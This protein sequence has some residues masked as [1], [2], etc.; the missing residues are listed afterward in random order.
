MGALI[1]GRGNALLSEAEWRKI[2]PIILGEKPDKGF[3][4]SAAARILKTTPARIEEFFRWARDDLE[5]AAWLDDVREAIRLRRH[6][7]LETLDDRMFDLAMN[8]DRDTLYDDA[9]NVIKVHVRE[10]MADVMKARDRLASNVEADTQDTPDG[11]LSTRL[12]RAYKL[13]K[14]EEMRSA[15]AEEADVS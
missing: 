12:E 3:G 4:V 5:G 11:D 2:R 1:E 10:R 8:G 13:L 9:G 14:A 7:I 15:Q 6:I